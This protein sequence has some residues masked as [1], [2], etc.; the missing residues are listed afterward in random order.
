MTTPH[1]AHGRPQGGGASQKDRP[2][3]IADALARE[4]AAHAPPLHGDIRAGLCIVG[5]GFTGLWTAILA[6]QMRPDLDIVLLE[7][8]LCGGG[9]SG[10]NGGCVSTW[11]TKFFTL[12]RLY[13]EAEAA[14]LVRASEQAVL[15]VERFCVEH[16]IDCE[17]Q[18]DGTLFTATARAQMGVSDV[19]M[20]A[21]SERQ[22]S[23]WTRLDPEDVKRRAGSNAHLEGWFSP[24]AAT[25]HPGK[26][27]R[28]LRRVAMNLGVRIHEQTP[29][30]RIEH[31]SPA[32]V[33]TPHGAVR[34]DSVV[35]ALNAWMAS[36]FPE[37]SRT[38][39]IVSSDMVITEPAPAQ[40]AETGLDGGISVMD[41]R[42]FVH[43]YRSTRDGRLMLGKG[44]NTF[45]YGGRMLRVFDEPSPFRELLT[46]RLREIMPP[47]AQVPVASSWNGP[48]DRSV[49]G[50]P[51]FG[52][53]QDARNVFYGFGYSGNG[54]G[55]TRIG[56]TILASLALGLDNE[57]T[58]SRLV[59]G[60]LGHFPPEPLRYAGSILVRNAIRRKERAEDAGRQPSVL[61]L[62]LSK[63]A[64]AAGKAD[65]A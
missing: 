38:I 20:A 16:G 50:M 10:R 35:V 33:R 32:I 5:G 23:S 55:P 64:S 18:R 26:L 28:G 17:W 45:A 12:Q 59:R 54:V 40:V 11:S 46:A 47:L 37:F 1:P 7:A 8:D 13:G 52:R 56:G 4:D 44:G 49:T 41:S 43:Y 29:M 24:M 15:D 3:W 58:R 61:D 30:L 60:P 48:S 62:R 27:V 51:F 6:K 14:R 53:L 9:A 19:V 34:A 42:T 25:V 22:I 39:A 2:F 21:L 31:G 57:W 65:K 63:F 36:K